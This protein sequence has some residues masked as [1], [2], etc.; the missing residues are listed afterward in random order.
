MTARTHGRVRIEDGAK[1]VRTMLGSQV[2]ADSRRVKLVWE[3]PYYPVYYFP[4]EDVDTE[5]L[6]ATGQTHKTPSRGE[7]AIHTVKAGSREA[8]DAVRWYTDSKIE[9]LNGYVTFRWD[10]MDS[11]FE[12]EEQ[13]YVHAR[14]PYTRVDILQ[15]SRHVEVVID[16]VKVADTHQPRLLFE[17]GLPTRYYIPK[18]DVRMDLLTPAERV[19]HCPYKGAANYYSV[20]I[21]GTEHD[22]LVWWYPNPVAESIR[23]AGYLCFYNEKVDTYVDGELEGRPQTVFS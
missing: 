20:M 23:I 1:R 17:T 22:N 16:G 3:K 2:V 5:L 6:V 4:I 10:A 13:V 12:E 8:P 21:D 19:T 11:W 7:S 15:S 18:T 9:E 14:D